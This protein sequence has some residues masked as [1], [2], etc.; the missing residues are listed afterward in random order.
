MTTDEDLLDDA[1]AAHSSRM[2]ELETLGA[3]ARGRGLDAAG[4][5]LELLLGATGQDAALILRLAE[6]VTRLRQEVA[7]LHDARPS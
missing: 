2:A 6:E 5:A 3:T 1:V 4:D 7:R